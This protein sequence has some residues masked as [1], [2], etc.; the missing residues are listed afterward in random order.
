MV[1]FELSE[2]QRE[3]QALVR[4]YAQEVVRPV[5]WEREKIRDWQ[6]RTPSEL[7]G[8]GSRRGIRT[9]SLPREWGGRGIDMLTICVIGEELA[10]ADAGIAIIFDHCWRFGRLISTSGSAHQKQTY[11]PRFRDDPDFWVGTTQT[12]A[13]RGGTAGVLRT[14]DEPMETTA[15]RD[16]DAWVLNGRKVYISNGAM[17]NLFTVQAVTDP[18]ATYPDGVSTFIVTRDMPGLGYGKVYAKIGTRNLI[19]AEVVFEDCRVP[20]E[21]LMG[22]EGRGTRL[23]EDFLG[24]THPE[25]G[26][27]ILGI[28]RTAYEETL[29]Y[30]RRRVASGKPIVEH[31]AVA[32]VIAE[33]YARIEAARQL[34][35]R[36]A[37][38]VDRNSPEGARLGWVAKTF[39]ADVAVW[40]TQQAVTTFGG[41]GIMEDYPVEKLAR[42]ALAYHHMHGTN[43]GLRIKTAAS[44]AAGADAAGNGVGEVRSPRGLVAV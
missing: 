10:A 7:I 30:A 22:V 42:D 25:I 35:W 33:M 43:D 37:W 29:R 38:E 41:A 9:L 24:S 19:N 3:L 44:L 39:A 14:S 18:T 5:A 20:A 13:N 28:A 40:V 23:A 34:I 6:E 32:L 2:E 8:E 21:N 4:R 27:I 17:A 1:S 36:A 16:G 11:I 26:A 15:R 31:Q 12:E